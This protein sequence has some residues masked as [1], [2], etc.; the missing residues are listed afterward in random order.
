P[1]P[2]NVVRICIGPRGVYWFELTTHGRTAHGSMPFLGVSAIDGMTDVLAA[3]RREL[4][5]LLAS[6]QTRMP[7]VPAD[8]RHATININALDRGPQVPSIQTPCLPHP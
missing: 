6:R 1:E 7:V 4:Q 8:A 2:L 5:P 3:I